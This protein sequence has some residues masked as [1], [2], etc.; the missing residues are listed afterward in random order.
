MRKEE[1]ERIAHIVAKREERGKRIL[2]A[3]LELE[4]DE[5]ANAERVAIERLERE[6]NRRLNSP[7]RKMTIEEIIR[8]AESAR[9]SI[10]VKTYNKIAR[11]KMRYGVMLA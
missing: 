5:V 9:Q 11:L 7:K 4:I 2:S 6:L 1:R 8:R 3:A 10:K